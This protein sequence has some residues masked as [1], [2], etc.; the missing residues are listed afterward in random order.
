MTG[1][2]KREL[3]MRTPKLRP[4]EVHS[5]AMHN[6]WKA[7]GSQ[8]GFRLYGTVDEW[9]GTFILSDGTHFNVPKLARDAIDSRLTCVD[10]QSMPPK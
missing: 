10:G 1:L 8:F 7:W 3:N 5:L 2:N 9:V 4:H 6:D